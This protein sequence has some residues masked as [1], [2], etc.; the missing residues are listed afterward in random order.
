MAG[1][2]ANKEPK[3]GVINTA[4]ILGDIVKTP[5][6]QKVIDEILATSADKRVEFAE[7]NLDRDGMVKRGIKPQGTRIYFK[8]ID[9]TKAKAGTLNKVMRLE[10]LI[11]NVG[12]I[13]LR[14]KY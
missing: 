2:Q 14:R 11:P 6:F 1:K 7:K 10:L 8:P 4:S 9:K 13:A 3:L 12:I 5:E